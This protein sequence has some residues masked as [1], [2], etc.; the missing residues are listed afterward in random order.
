[1]NPTG[2]HT[3]MPTSRHVAPLNQMMKMKVVFVAYAC[4]ENEEGEPCPMASEETYISK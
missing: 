1:M 3:S 2:S 4:E